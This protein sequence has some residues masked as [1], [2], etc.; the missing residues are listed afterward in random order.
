MI[1]AF[2][3]DLGG[4]LFKNPTEDFLK[5][6]SS[7]LDVEKKSLKDA[8]L[9]LKIPFQ[10]GLI[11]EKTFWKKIYKYLNISPTKIQNSLWEKAASKVL[12]EKTSMLKLV[13]NLKKL[14]YKVALLSNI[15]KPTTKYL[16]KK[17]Y[18]KLF[19][20]IIFSCDVKS[21]KPQ[22]KIFKTALKKLKVSAKETVFIDDIPEF[23]EAAKT[24]GINGIV[25]RNYV[26][27]L[28]DLKE[29]LKS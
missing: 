9:R 11:D 21:V 29:F 25:Y 4:V 6:F 14:G 17:G 15:E 18:N 23:V 24:L 2:I 27:L 10:K 16:I 7:A 8:Y 5:F 1:R 19:D 26:K 22:K 3:F 13:K 12:K 28:K 20:E